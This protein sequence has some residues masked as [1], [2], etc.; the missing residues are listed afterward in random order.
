VSETLSP[1]VTA[2]A[3]PIVASPPPRGARLRA[4]GIGLARLAAAATSGALLS[5]IAPPR[6]LHALHWS[7]LVPL[8]VAL[9]AGSLKRSVRL[10]FAAGFAAQ[11]T[12]FSWIAPTL[13]RFAS[14]PKPASW[15]LLALF[16]AVFA[17]PYAIAFGVAPWLRERLGALW[18]VAMPAWLVAV[19]RLTPQIFPYYQGVSQYRVA[20][21]FQL[22]SVAGVMG[23][24]FLV[25]LVNTAIADVVLRL[26]EKRRPAW[27]ALAGV[28]ALYAANLAFGAWRTARVEGLLAGAKTIRV[29]QLQTTAMHRVPWPQLTR[30]VTSEHPD[31]VVWPESAISQNPDEP[32]T[33]ALLSTLAREGHFDLFLG[34][35]TVERPTPKQRLEYNSTY[36]FDKNGEL[37]GRYDKMVL[38]PFGE[39][40]PLADVIP[41]LKKI[42]GP[43]DIV[44]GK[45]P[46]VLRGDGYTFTGP[47]CYEA[48]LEGPMRLL[49]DA[50]LV[51]N[52]TND[53]WFGDTAAP[54][55]HAML[56]AVK[57][58][59]IGRP[60]VRS[61]YTGVSFVV[62][63][64]GRILH[65][66]RPFT[67]VAE[68]HPVRLAR[69][70]T[71]YSRGGFVFPWLCVAAAL[72]AIVKG[73]RAAPKAPPAPPA[74]PVVAEPVAPAP[75]PPPPAA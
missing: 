18:I 46:V 30:R 50:D 3:A 54:H 17:L 63:P 20:W 36:H 64:H 8:L 6:N 32:S 68:V 55:Q 10:A 47:V 58:V 15:A 51:V 22:A 53:G 71:V 19:E 7:A 35:G 72:G 31:L 24:S 13:V 67:E 11:I 14:L 60:L 34:G 41:A 25:V 75:E 62:E 57:A 39:Y 45:A 56:A 16:A 27:G 42:P 23:V 40:M 49:S 74:P 73:R 1:P 43:G 33:R 2:P 9:P 48:I 44:P 69:V 65:E 21:T 28:G 37:A 5:V 61:A 38:L 59:E 70:D 66:T 12:I 52:V 26:R 4:L 29:A